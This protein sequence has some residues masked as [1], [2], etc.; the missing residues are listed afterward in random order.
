MKGIRS[1]SG[2]DARE[3]IQVLANQ[4][5]ELAQST[6][7]PPIVSAG[8]GQ[9]PTAAAGGG[10]LSALAA[11]VG[12]GSGNFLLK[13]LTLAP[14]IN[15]LVGLFR[16]ES[17]DEVSAPVR[18][19]LPSPIRTEAGLAPNGQTIS[20]DRGA[21]DRIRALRPSD[22]HVSQL[23]AGRSGTETGSVSTQNI[24]VQVSAMDSRSFLDHSED[25]AR[26][27]RDAMLHSH[28]LNDVVNDL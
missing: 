23:V 2:T 5:G 21:G 15:G 11:D 26:A 16:K 14:L 7:R 3:T 25:I 22:G 18:F 13:G 27:V 28:S 20:I 9:T 12:R 10:A 24:T 4:I 1:L 17:A 6:Y 8:L 19:S